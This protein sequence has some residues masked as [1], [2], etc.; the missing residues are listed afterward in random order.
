MSCCTSCSFLGQVVLRFNGDQIYCNICS[1]STQIWLSIE[2]FSKIGVGRN[3]MACYKIRITILTYMNRVYSYSF[4]IH[5]YLDYLAFI[6]HRKN[7]W[8]LSKKRENDT[9]EPLA[10][11]YKVNRI[12]NNRK[13]VGSSSCSGHYFWP[14]RMG[15]PFKSS[16]HPCSFVFFIH[17]YDFLHDAITSCPRTIIY[18][19]KDAYHS[20]QFVT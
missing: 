16:I 19:D 17:L 2:A 4:V 7:I 9:E 10:K 13:E 11:N 3:C 8:L 15:T 14:M 6:P 18:L 12:G 1:I 20:I 5:Q